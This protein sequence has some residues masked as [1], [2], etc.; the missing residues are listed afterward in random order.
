[1]ATWWE[2]LSHLKRPWYWERLRAGGEGDDKR[3]RW[4]DGITD[5]MDM[6][7][8]RFWELMVD[9]EAWRA[10]V[11]GVA[12]SRTWL[13]DWTERLL[14]VKNWKFLKLNYLV[15]FIVCFKGSFKDVKNIMECSSVLSIRCAPIRCWIWWTSPKNVSNE[16]SPDYNPWNFWLC[17]HAWK[18]DFADSIMLRTLRW[19]DYPRLSR[20][21]QYTHK[22]P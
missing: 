6:S 14:H 22:G 4:L 10:V 11:H 17:L 2:E 20:Q 3:M 18:R 15:N 5:S 7:L 13:S 9:R 16:W 21:G 8:G 12:K 1:M 19:G